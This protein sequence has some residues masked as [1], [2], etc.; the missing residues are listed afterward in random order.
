MELTINFL[1]RHNT[2]LLA[3]L[4][5]LTLT[6]RVASKRFLKEMVMTQE[7]DGHRPQVNPI[8]QVGP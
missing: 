7:D 3:M 1:M 6:S 5:N 4:I 8:G 2:H